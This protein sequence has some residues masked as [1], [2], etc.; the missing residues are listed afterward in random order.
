MIQSIIFEKDQWTIKHALKWLLKNKYLVIKID[1][2]DHSY[3]F[4]QSDLNSND[5]YY[6]KDMG[7]GLK[8]VIKNTSGLVTF[9]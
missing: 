1:E 4:H 6:I 9:K 7:K 8:F 5:N 3:K 2:T